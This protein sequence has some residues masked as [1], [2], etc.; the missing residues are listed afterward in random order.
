MRAVIRS[1]FCRS[2]ILSGAMF[3]IAACSSDEDDDG[4]GTVAGN[5]GNPSVPGS[6]GKAGVGSGGS[7]NSSS[8]KGGSTASA[9]KSSGSGATGNTGVTPE[10]SGLPFEED[11]EEGEESCVGVDFE[12]EPVATDLFI[13]M[14]RSISQDKTIDGSDTIK[15]WD[16]LRDAVAEFTENAKNSDIR[17]GIGFFGRTGGADDEL[18]CDVDFYAKPVVEIGAIADVGDA[19]VEAIEDQYP[20][21]QTPT[22]P[23]LEGAHRYAAEYAEENPSRVVSVVLVTDGFPTQ[24][25]TASSALNDLAERAR[26]E[27]P[28]VRTFVIGVEGTWNL[29]SVARAGGTT[30]AYLIDEGDTTASFRRALDNITNSPVPCQFEIPEPPSEMERVDPEQVQVVY[31]PASGDPEEIP[32]VV[33]AAACNDQRAKNGGWYYDDNESPHNILVCGCTCSRFGAGSVS[34]RLGCEPRV[35]IR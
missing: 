24:C 4:V 28:Y 30:A 11:S 15:R 19:L 1:W 14:D 22:L 6:G 17:V 34:V 26:G 3:V 33:S 2:L 5:V 7:G 21:G 35:G 31:T 10:C 27:E 29:D 13:M 18:D 9:G 32:R 23:A 25:S 16:A 12:A 8:S 20:S